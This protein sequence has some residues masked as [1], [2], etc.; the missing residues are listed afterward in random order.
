MVLDE[1]IGINKQEEQDQILDM[2]KYAEQ[3]AQ[4]A[5]VDQTGKED[6]EVI[7]DGVD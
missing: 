1:D 2:N 3:D 6:K 7:V 5:G 4:V